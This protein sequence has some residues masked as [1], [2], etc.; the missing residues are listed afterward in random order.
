MH[1]VVIGLVKVIVHLGEPGTLLPRLGFF[2]LDTVAQGG[3]P[4]V[5]RPQLWVEVSQPDR[6]MNPEKVDHIRR[7]TEGEPLTTM[8][9]VDR[10]EDWIDGSSIRKL[11]RDPKQRP[12]GPIVPRLIEELRELGHRFIYLD[13]AVR[14]VFVAHCLDLMVIASR[15]NPMTR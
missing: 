12:A 10:G 7:F 8:K 13:L 6:V 9:S 5:E 15:D 1:G 11:V 4:L 3:P 2:F 14:S